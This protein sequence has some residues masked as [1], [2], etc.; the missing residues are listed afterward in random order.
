M[1]IGG[2]KLIAV[3]ILQNISTKEVII[4]TSTTCKRRFLCAHPLKSLTKAEVGEKP[5]VSIDVL[6]LLIN[7]VME[8]PDEV[9]C[10]PA[11]SFGLS[12][13]RK[14]P[15]PPAQPEVQTP[16][17]AP[18]NQMTPKPPA[19]A[20]SKPKLQLKCTYKLANGKLSSRLCTSSQGHTIVCSCSI[21]LFLTLALPFPP[22]AVQPQAFP[23]RLHSQDHADQAHATQEQPF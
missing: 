20:K 21:T 5:Q 11:K 13:K 19:K 14:L 12:H 2:A 4:I 17:K 1:R 16:N 23:P 3:S 10:E 7:R 22:R 6:H 18:K 8:H 15:L 9:S